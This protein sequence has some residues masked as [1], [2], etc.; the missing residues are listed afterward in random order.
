MRW[1]TRAEL[2]FE[3]MDVSSLYFGQPSVFALYAQGLTTGLVI[4][5]GECTTSCMPVVEGHCIA[6]AAQ[7]MQYGGRTVTEWLGR[8]R[9]RA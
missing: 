4:D 8:V 6:P 1:L 5:S 9:H 3:T 2:L 7:T